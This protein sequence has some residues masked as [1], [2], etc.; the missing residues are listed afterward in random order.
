MKRTI[1]FVFLTLL[2]LG[3]GTIL[4]R[5]SADSEVSLRAVGEV[6]G[7]VMQDADRIGQR[8]VKISP[9]EERE[10]GRRVAQ[11]LTSYEGTGPE[12]QRAYVREVG[13]LVARHAR[14]KDVTYEFEVLQSDEV[15]A[16]ALPGGHI[17][18]TTGLFRIMTSE[19]ELAGVLGHE[20]THV[21]LR[22][23]VERLQYRIA[24]RKV[25]GPLAELAVAFGHD[26]YQRAYSELQETAADE[27]GTVMAMH[28]GYDPWET[29]NLME[30]MGDKFGE[31]DR[32]K[33]RS[34]G[35][36][37]GQVV[38]GAVNDYFQTHPPFRQ[39]IVN[40]EKTARR[41][42]SGERSP[43]W[44]I[45]RVNFQTLTAR[46]IEELPGEWWSAEP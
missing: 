32:S 27:G 40:I 31:L 37:A 12:K 15:N 35:R 41:S 20:I 23:C 45:G 13:K 5:H 42:Q 6:A 26:M 30:R 10:I 8:I 2:T 46:S 18:M 28:A 25:G 34:P 14:R 11:M 3:I 9:A 17:F 36:E 44:Y 24:A 39:R 22:H 33:P 4:V 43:R 29:V 38:V 7:E 1:P 21:D 16:F 19:A